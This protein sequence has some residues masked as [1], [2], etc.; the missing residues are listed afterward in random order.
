MARPRQYSSAAERQAA[1]KARNNVTSAASNVTAEP[2]NVT[3]D[4]GFVTEP[5]TLLPTEPSNV[6]LAPFRHQPHV[7]LSLFDGQGR[8]TVR[9]HTDGRAYV[10]V[11][12]HAGSDLGELGIVSATDWHARLGQHCQHGHAGWSCH[13]C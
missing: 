8:G 9:T 2:S 3:E 12:R 11:S 13:T 10:M 6:T 1:F 5:V 7:P 4:G